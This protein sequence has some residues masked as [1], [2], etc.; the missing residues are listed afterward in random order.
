MSR[1]S[2]VF[3]VDASSANTVTV[4]LRS[5]A[6]AKGAGDSPQ[7]ALN[8]LSGHC[9][10]W[11][12]LFDNADDTTLNLSAY[13]PPCSHGNI[14][15]TSRNPATCIYALSP[16][17]SCKVS[18]LTLD[19]ARGLLLEIAGLRDDHSNE[20]EISATAIVQVMLLLSSCLGW[21]V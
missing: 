2:E 7:D 9:E 21:W 16:K 4:D 15:I 5:L 12:L 1:F 11:L 10:E 14:L 13:F 17:S 19:D 20:M 6:Q 18:N 3:F 8:W